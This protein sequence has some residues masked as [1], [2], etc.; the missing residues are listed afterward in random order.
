MPF[1]TE[2]LKAY[3]TKNIFSPLSGYLYDDWSQLLRSQK[4]KISPRYIPRACF[5]TLAS[6]ANTRAAAKEKAE[7]DVEISNTEI[8]PPIFVLGHWR[9]GTTHLH[10]LLSIDSRFAYPTFLEATQPHTF[11]TTGE[12]TRNS[13]LL[14]A[15][16]PNTRLIDN[17]SA[18]LDAPM[19]D[20]VALCILSNLSPIMSNLFPRN[21]EAFDKYLTFKTASN[22]EVEF[23]K[24]QF[25]YF[26]KKL[27][28]KYQRPMILKSPPHTCRI[29]LI[30]EMFPDAKFINIHRNPYTVF[31]SYKRSIIIMNKMIR[32]QNYE[33]SNLDQ[34]I[35]QQYRNLYDN[36]FAEQALIPENQFSEVAYDD[37]IDNP[38]AEL[39]RVYSDL[40]LSI[41]K[42]LTGNWQNYLASISNYKKSSLDN[43]PDELKKSIHKKWRNCFETWDYP[44]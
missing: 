43:L 42:E 17:V 44:A 15:L 32:V 7:Y 10:N 28:L 3:L 31:K 9:S 8:P 35:M 41:D 33:S 19:E 2:N 23:W 30:L 6:L 12:K 39:E 20:E 37:L 22:D 25:I 27:T 13:K 24:Q 29:K 38:I 1:L 18:T 34:R 26:I 14:K 40:N 11:L 21:A 16:S 36:Y 4:Y 5:M